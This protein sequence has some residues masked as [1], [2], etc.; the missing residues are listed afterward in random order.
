MKKIVVLTGAGISAESGLSTFRDSDGLWEN[1]SIEDVATPE[2]FKRNPELVHQFYN[3]RRRQL[4]DK[5]IQPNAAHRALVELEANI[6][7]RV[8]KKK[9]QDYFLLVTQNVDNLHEQAGQENVI[10][11]HGDLLKIRCLTCA[12]IISFTRAT[13]CESICEHCQQV[14]SIRPHIV[15]FNEMPLHLELIYQALE[16]CSLFMAIGTSGS[17]Y[18][19][20]DFVGQ[21]RLAGA[22]TIEINLE[23]SLVENFFNE[24]LYGKASRLVPQVVEKLLAEMS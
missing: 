18:P 2:G 17:V 16:R 1:H 11:M 10:H 6:L 22:N 14:G 15:W 7:S 13:S 9:H 19:A 12:K 8:N 5:N 3:E 20:A 4:Q 24:K 23:P 21:A